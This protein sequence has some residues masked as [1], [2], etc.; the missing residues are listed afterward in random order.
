MASVKGFPSG[1]IVADLALSVVALVLLA[2][3]L[4]AEKRNN[5]RLKLAT[6]TPLSALF[7]VV[8]VMQPHPAPPY[9]H[10]ILV[11]LVL[12]LI[13]DVCLALQG[14]KAFR[15][16]LV[17]FLLGHVAYVV[18]FVGLTES[19]DWM[20]PVHLLVVAVGAGV[21]WWLYPHLGAMRVPVGLYV[22]V[23]SV[24]AAAAWVA[25]SNPALNRTGP[26]ALL[27]GAVSF[28]VSDIFVARDRFMKPAFANRLLG[29]PLYYA[30]QFL[31]AFSVGLIR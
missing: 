4:A 2:G 19:R 30:G 1:G 10:A 15:A 7:V 28:Y 22:I 31:L 24:M 17:S 18:A 3:L 26:W 21:F 16:G 6:K 9:Y 23:I 14:N 27:L 12:G 11:G 13:G 29:L 25:F 20:T 8:A 5:T